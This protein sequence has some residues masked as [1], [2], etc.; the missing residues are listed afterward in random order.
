MHRFARGSTH[1]IGE[2]RR[3]RRDRD[4]KEPHPH[5]GGTALPRLRARGG[6][7]DGNA[8]TPAASKNA[9]LSKCRLV[10]DIVAKAF[11]HR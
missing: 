2:R 1:R 6:K 5:A 8:P 3:A 9:K 7:A 4:V 11:L 10:A